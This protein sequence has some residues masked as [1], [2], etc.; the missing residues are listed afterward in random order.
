MND[1]FPPRGQPPTD[2]AARDASDRPAIAAPS[3]V[4]L[5]PEPQFGMIDIVESFTAL[6]Q[7]ARTQVRENRELAKTLQQTTSQIEALERRLLGATDRVQQA[8][9]QV[10]SDEE[11]RR[12][13]E[14]IADIDHHVSRAV[15][16][17]LRVNRAPE[18]TSNAGDVEKLQHDIQQRYAQ[19]G[20]LARWFARG[21]LRDVQ[22]AVEQS[23]GP[24]VQPPPA[25][26]DPIQ[27]GLE[28][29]V[30]RIRRLMAQQHIRRIDTEGLPFDGGQMHAVDAID[31]ADHPSGHVV[32]QLQPAYTFRGTLI[33]FADVRVAK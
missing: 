3:D 25:R 11:A 31:S 32:Q 12:L 6:R 24:S 5:S 22:D 10:S 21:F 33:K 2:D 1:A 14:T 8:V 26:Q 20:P 15:E 29:V 18:D 19:L 30:Q 4:S 13:A 16:A 17:V 7:E 9:E 28:M 27:Q 23:A